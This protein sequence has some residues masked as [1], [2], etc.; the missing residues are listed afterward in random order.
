MVRIRLR[1]AGS[2]RQPHYRIVVTDS[3]NKRDGRFIEVLGYYNPRTQ[4]ETVEYKE[5]RALY[6]LSVGAKPS[7]SVEKFFARYGTL[8]RLARLR[9]GESMETL[10]AE[11]EAAKASREDVSPKTRYDAVD[12]PQPTPVAEIVE[13][14]PT[15][16]E[17]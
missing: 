16:T 3:R 14:E 4:P 5:D 10:V 8:D 9:A 12:K 6:W 15:S 17:E 7:E 13:E 11:A 2:K 1:R